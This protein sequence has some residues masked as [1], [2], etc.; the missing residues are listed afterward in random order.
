[1]RKS[2]FLVLFIALI[3]LPACQPQLEVVE[4]TRLVEATVAGSQPVVSETVQVTRVVAEEVTRVVPQ[5]V[6]VEVTRPLLGSAVRPV[7]LLFP[8][9]VDTNVIKLRGSALAE[10][11][12][13]TTGR[14][15]EIGVLDSEA[16]VI[17]LTCSAPV[18]TISFLPAAGYVVAHDRC[19]A[20]AGNV[21]VHSD[22]L[23]WQAGM[24]VVRADSGITA[25]EDLAGRRWAVP[26]DSSTYETL[27]F[28]AL[29]A[30]A[31]IEVGEMVE[32]P[33]DSSAMLAVYNREVDFA[34]ATFVPPILPF[35]ER[36]WRYGEDDPEI[37]R[38]VG[39]A[40]QRSPIGYVVVN[41]EPEFGGYRVRDARSGI[42]DT[43]PGIFNETRILTLSAQI[44]NETVVFGAD[45]PLGLAREVM[46]T[47]A[48]FT[49][50]ESCTT[51]LCSTDFYGWTGVELAQDAFYD[52]LRFTM[53]TL[54]L[55]P[56]ELLTK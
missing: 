38:R 5:E 14:N 27:Y 29:F 36:R 23:T 22:G 25:L 55:S 44:P 48:D 30:D 7:Q 19:N 45:F 11:L 32:V 28:R 47:L 54:N 12:A 2:W 56:E 9:V 46:A 24:I 51:S 35:E 52:P 21:A 18:D 43:T 41:G 8:P 33:G 20:Q 34:I 1:M 13:E 31:G 26:S 42:L 49:A 6:T 3:L 16:S 17:E 39:L 10:A 40:P 53:E 4:V 15:Y 37:W 50:S